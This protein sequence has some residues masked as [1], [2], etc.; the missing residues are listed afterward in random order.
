[1]NGCLIYR[2]LFVTV[3]QYTT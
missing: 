3:L 2:K 1:M